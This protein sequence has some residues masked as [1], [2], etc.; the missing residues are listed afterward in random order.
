[1]EAP[2][3]LGG[4]ELEV[5]ET[6]QDVPGPDYPLYYRVCAVRVLQPGEWLTHNDM[7]DAPPGDGKACST[8]VRYPRATA[9]A[10]SQ[11]SARSLAPQH[12]LLTSQSA[13]SAVL[14]VAAPEILAPTS[15]S[16]VAQGQLRLQVS[17]SPGTEN[18][19]AEVEFTWQAPRR[20]KLSDSVSAVPARAVWKVPVDE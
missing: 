5:A 1:M 2:E 20:V 7:V 17:P 6:L 18:G 11:S 16:H 15:G 4:R 14:G 8:P 3:G 12:T 13:A 19:Q 10:V 9:Q